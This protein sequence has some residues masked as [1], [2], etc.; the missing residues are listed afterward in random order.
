[1]NALILEETIHRVAHLIIDECEE[2]QCHTARFFRKY[3][4]QSILFDSLLRQA[5]FLKILMIFISNTDEKNVAKILYRIFCSL[6]ADVQRRA[7]ISKLI[8]QIFNKRTDVCHQN[9]SL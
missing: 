7:I 2:I 8:D 6:G 4:K 5:V 1:M 9:N 3:L